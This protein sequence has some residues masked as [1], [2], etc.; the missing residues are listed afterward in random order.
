MSSS[1]NPPTMRAWT[2]RTRGP[3]G[4]V[5]K[6]ESNLPMPAPPAKDNVLI[7]ISHSALTPTMA[8]LPNYIPSLPFLSRPFTP[9]LDL[10]GVVV[11]GGPEAPETLKPGTQVWGSEQIHQFMLRGEGTMAEYIVLPAKDVMPLPKGLDLAEAAALNGN[12]Q[13]AALMVKN[14]KVKKGSRVFI[15]G[16]SG[17]VGTL[18]VQI[19]KAEGA[20][21]VATGSGENEKLVKELGADEVSDASPAYHVLVIGSGHNHLL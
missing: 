15:N 3:V 5:L 7:K 11:Q 17:G 21:V 13:T 10:S 19:A 9:E 18:L 20:Y 6:L 14:G 8:Y 4:T 16:G 1:T 2:Y 12:G